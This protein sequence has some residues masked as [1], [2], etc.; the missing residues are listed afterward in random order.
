MTGEFWK[1][2]GSKIWIRAGK[3]KSVYSVFHLIKKLLRSAVTLVFFFMFCKSIFIYIKLMFLCILLLFWCINIK[4]LKK[5][6]NIFLNKNTL[7][8]ILNHN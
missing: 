2:N 4:K 3:G 7:K 1:S 5:Y 8:N 6:F